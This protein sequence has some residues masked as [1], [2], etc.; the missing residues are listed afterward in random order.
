LLHYASMSKTVISPSQT[1]HIATLAHLTLTPEQ[2]ETQ[3]QNL[4][5]IL[6]Y[7]DRIKGLDLANIPATA[8]VT[9]EQNVWREDQI[10]PSLSQAD[11][12]RGAKRTHQGYFVVDS[13]FAERE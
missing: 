12:L 4:T 2:L 3:S 7:M 10:T 5:A 13:I 8:R 6:D 1:Q 11:A 9:D